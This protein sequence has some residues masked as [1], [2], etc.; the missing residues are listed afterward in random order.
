MNAPRYSKRKHLVHNPELPPSPASHPQPPDPHPNVDNP[1]KP[2]TTNSPDSPSPPTSR[3]RRSSLT[4]PAPRSH[5]RSSR[6]HRSLAADQFRNLFDDDHASN[7]PVLAGLV[8]EL[9]FIHKIDHEVI[10]DITQ[11]QLR[12][13]AINIPLVDTDCSNLDLVLRNLNLPLK[14]R[15]SG[16]A[17]LAQYKNREWL[18]K[19]D[20]G[21]LL[22]RL[23]LILSLGKHGYKMALCGYGRWPCLRWR[24]SRCWTASTMRGEP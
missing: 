18:R 1:G 10:A 11:N 3:S 5:P 12:L 2:T 16:Y 20:K 13:P 4:K 7:Y 21:Q 17:F 8:D 14:L 24:L 15:I 23:A 22:N 6:A 9:E 19:L